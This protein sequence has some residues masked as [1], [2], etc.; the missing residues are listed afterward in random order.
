MSGGKK[1][2]DHSFWAGKGSGGSVLPVG[3]KMK[4]ESSA[5]GAGG[6]STYEDTTEK[7]KSQQEQGI[8][9]AKGHA[10]KPSYRN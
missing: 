8:S 2:N 6:I 1:I 4:Q 3:C 7:I 5:E 10:Q 9:K